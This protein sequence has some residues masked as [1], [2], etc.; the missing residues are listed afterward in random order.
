MHS[1]IHS[2][3]LLTIRRS[4]ADHPCI[5][6]KEGEKPLKIFNSARCPLSLG[7]AVGGEAFHSSELPQK[8]LR[9]EYFI[10]VALTV[11]PQITKP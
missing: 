1:L 3:S 10:Y 7:E 6:P 2:I 9:Q 4:K 11:I 5:S 8:V